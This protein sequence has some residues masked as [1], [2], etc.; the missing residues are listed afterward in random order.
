MN[1]STATP[2]LPL[3]AL[4]ARVD[5]SAAAA[6]RLLHNRRLRANWRRALG[7]LEFVPLEGRPVDAVQR[8]SL[9][10]PH[11]PAEAC[12]SAPD[13]P[14][15]DVVTASHP[16]TVPAAL[17]QLAAE[18]LMQPLLDMLSGIGL[19]DV[20]VAGLATVEGRF[21]DVPSAGWVR[22]LRDGEPLVS[23]VCTRLPDAVV[24]EVGQRLTPQRFVS[25]LGRALAWRGHVTLTART[26]R[27]S[28]LESLAQ[29]DVLLLASGADEQ[30]VDCRVS[31]G[32][33]GARRWSATATVDETFL[34]IQGA[35]RMIDDEDDFDSQPDGETA[36]SGGQPPHDIDVPVRFEIDT[37]A[38]PL[39]EIEAM[40]HGYVIE[41][42]TPLSTAKIRLVACG[43]VIGSADLVAVGDR[44]GA[45]ITHM[46]PRDAARHVD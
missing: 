28:V 35:G 1:L 2:S 46:A 11:G 22:L 5:S 33:R 13:F 17:Q 29:G 37:V 15:V 27:R 26:V 20:T 41:L 16:S 18:A 6:S 32:A 44:L 36:A 25:R 23:F 12:F 42:A 45:R 3:S 9:Q 8:V 10:T 43:R 31:F 4:L 14:S 30:R 38:L 39:A 19:A 40:A 34:T 7:G 21:D 24:R